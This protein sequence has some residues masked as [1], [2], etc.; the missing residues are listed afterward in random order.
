MLN[1]F[2]ETWYISAFCIIFP[3]WN[4]SGSLNLSSWNTRTQLQY[5]VTRWHGVAWRQGISNHGFV[6]ILECSSP[7][8]TMLQFINVFQAKYVQTN[9]VLYMF[10]LTM[11]S[12]A[13]CLE[14]HKYNWG[15]LNS[16]LMLWHQKNW[17][18]GF[19]CGIFCNL[20]SKNI[21]CSFKLTLIVLAP[22]ESTHGLFS[23]VHI[24]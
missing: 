17:H 3:L 6:L 12:I 22:A 11:H 24:L 2:E 14:L 20:L 15:I 1:C 4:G 16:H 5:I 10:I 23:V 9:K 7:S 19:F 21:L 18:A 13:V 8:I